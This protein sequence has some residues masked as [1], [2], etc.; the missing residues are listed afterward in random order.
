MNKHPILT[1]CAIVAVSVHAEE[2]KTVCY[3]GDI[4]HVI[5]VV[6]PYGWEL[7]CEV[8]FTTP[9]ESRVVWRA[10]SDAGFCERKAQE[11]IDRRNEQQWQC[12]E[13]KIINSPALTDSSLFN[14]LPPPR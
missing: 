1:L 13:E 9:E 11:I 14:D 5:Q 7:P 4:R 12:R 6:H 10:E 3:S 8:H 2:V